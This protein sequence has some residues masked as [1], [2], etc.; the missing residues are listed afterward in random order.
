MK[1]NNLNGIKCSVS[2]SKHLTVESSLKLCSSL[3]SV[4][5]MFLCLTNKFSDIKMKA[6]LSYR[7]RTVS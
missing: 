4:S 1:V 7:K 5:F 3:V 2:L 6:R